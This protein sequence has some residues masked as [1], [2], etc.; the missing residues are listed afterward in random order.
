MT[1]LSGLSGLSNGPREPLGSTCVPWQ[2]FTRMTSRPKSQSRALDS[3][4]CPVSRRSIDTPSASAQ[5]RNGRRAACSMEPAQQTAKPTVLFT[6]HDAANRS[7]LDSSGARLV[8]RCGARRAAQGQGSTRS[9]VAL[10]SGSLAKRSPE[11]TFRRPSSAFPVLRAQAGFSGTSRQGQ[12]TSSSQVRAS[13]IPRMKGPRR[14][15]GSEVGL[16]LDRD[17]RTEAGGA[18]RP[19]AERT[20]GV[21]LV[22]VWR[23]LT[24]RVHLG[25]TRSANGGRW[26][27]CPS[28]AAPKL[29]G[30]RRGH[31]RYSRLSPIDVADGAPRHN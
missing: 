12:Q 28:F 21:T 4:P 25:H 26:C 2:R 15:R 19:E 22:L 10:T 5:R 3:L 11:L 24:V 18:V 31:S 27:G 14:F 7:K 13:C 30:V 23:F 8:E 29:I 20:A 6:L 16:L 1:L 9:D 17:V